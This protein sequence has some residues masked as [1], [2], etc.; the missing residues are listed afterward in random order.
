MALCFHIDME[1]GVQVKLQQ[2]PIIP[3][4]WLG[5]PTTLTL[6]VFIASLLYLWFRLEDEPIKIWQAKVKVTEEFK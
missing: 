2:W 5:L 4:A 1:L 3:I 6:E